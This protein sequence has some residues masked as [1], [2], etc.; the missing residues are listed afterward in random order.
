LIK[1]LKQQIQVA[2]LEEKMSRPKTYD[3]AYTKQPVR[4]IKQQLLMF[5]SSIVKPRPSTNV[6]LTHQG[7]HKNLPVLSSHA[8]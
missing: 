1:E 6:L 7:V 5:D 3:A 4:C 2:T 8:N